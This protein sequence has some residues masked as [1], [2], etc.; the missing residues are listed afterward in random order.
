M[1]GNT[2]KI[3]PT[4]EL[5]MLD[6]QKGDLEA[7]EVLYERY[8]KRLFHFVLRFMKERLTAED[9]LQETFLRLLKGKKRFFYLFPQ[10][11]DLF[12]TRAALWTDSHI[13]IRNLLFRTCR[14][15]STG[16]GAGCWGYFC[17][18]FDSF[19][20]RAVP[21]ICLRFDFYHGSGNSCRSTLRGNGNPLGVK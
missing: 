10:R 12:C 5:L 11:V 1:Q 16:Q 15:E 8:H 18:F 9:I 19:F 13:H 17:S 2:N 14:G 20:H 3:Q 21:A 4:D 6:V 7:F